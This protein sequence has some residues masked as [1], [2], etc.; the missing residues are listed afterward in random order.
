MDN[1]K[2][3]IKTLAVVVI[4]C[5]LLVNR[6]AA[7]V[8][9]ANNIHYITGSPANFDSL[10][11]KF[12]GKII[13]VDMWA[14]WCHPCRLELQKTKDI[15]TFSDFALKNDIVIL[16]I[17]CDNN[18]KSWKGFIKN[19]KLAGYHV[20]DNDS[21]NTDLHRR[22]S[23]E[24][25]GRMTLKYGFYIPRHLIIDQKGAVADSMADPQGS[26]LVY[27]RLNRLIANPAK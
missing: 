20:L 25:H 19:Y 3:S 9:K 2:Q 13:Y 7:Q 27:A 18:G 1:F 26:A 22:F 4:A 14:T 6:S 16:Y 17:C 23:Y 5:I 10:I 12:K 11:S 8:S 24:L 15:K 21:L